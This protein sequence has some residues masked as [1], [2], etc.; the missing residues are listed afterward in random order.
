M[1]NLS[2]VYAARDF[3]ENGSKPGL[4]AVHK[5]DTLEI[6]VENR[7]TRKYKKKQIIY[8]EGSRPTKLYYIKK[9]MVKIFKSNSDGKELVI[10]LHNEGELL[11]YASLMDGSNYRET[12]QTLQDTELVIIPGAEFEEMITGNWPV[13]KKLI[14]LMAGDIIRQ[15]EQMLNIAY[16]SL[17]RKVAI[18]LLKVYKKFNT[19]IRM[20]RENLAAIAGTATESLTK[21]FSELKKENIID[22]KDGNIMIVDIKRLMQLAE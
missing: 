17:R 14:S 21:T 7:D 19:A 18:A 22:I 12:A 9:G 11:G 4:S 6:L 16:N 1:N 15:N 5:H 8:H 13:A 20:S 10:N 3:W 2:L